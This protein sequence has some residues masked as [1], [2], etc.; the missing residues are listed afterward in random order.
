MFSCSFHIHCLLLSFINV[1]L[2]FPYTLFTFFF[3]KCL[4]RITYNEVRCDGP[5]YNVACHISPEECLGDISCREI[6]G[7]CR[8][9]ILLSLVLPVTESCICTLVTYLAHCFTIPQRFDDANVERKKMFTDMSHHQ[10]NI[11]FLLAL[12]TKLILFIEQV[13]LWWTAELLGWL[14][15]PPF[16]QVEN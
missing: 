2:F 1:Q 7:L 9:Q 15:L 4:Y 16:L 5:H 14:L 8:V 11:H 12:F 10:H 6:S 13:G 3:H